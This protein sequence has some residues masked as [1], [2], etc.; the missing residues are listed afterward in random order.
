MKSF[1]YFSF[2]L[3]ACLVCAT[4]HSCDFFKNEEDE[5]SEPA[6]TD[7]AS[8]TVTNCERVGAVLIID[9]TMTN[10]TK[11]TL[12]NVTIY[13]NTMADDLG[14]EYDKYNN[15]ISVNRGEFG[16]SKTFSVLADETVRL[17]F[18]IPS[19][20]TT[21]KATRINL[22]FSCN[23]SSLGVSGNVT[24][25]NLTITDNR[26]ISN[27][28]QTPD[29]GLEIEAVDA[30]LDTKDGTTYLRFTVKNVTGENITSFNLWRFS[31]SDDTGTVAGSCGIAVGTDYSTANYS[32]YNN[33][34]S[35]AANETVTYICKISNLSK[36]ASRVSGYID[37]TTGSY[38]LADG[39]IRFFDIP[40]TARID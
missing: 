17:R 23:L 16:S 13:P 30:L 20:D 1:K 5:P 37:C 38:V 19:F 36:N 35:I 39:R 29:N 7:Y 24:G 25:S 40:I 32:Y 22:Y 15:M 18:K 8:F 9:A 4:L 26:V 12:R 34:R 28:V 11:E 31:F 2:L 27:G 33:S 10:K 14:N 6:V 21:N 3:L